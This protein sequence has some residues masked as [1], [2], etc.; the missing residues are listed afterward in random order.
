MTKSRLKE[1]KKYFRD[2]SA[3]NPSRSEGLASGTP[4]PACLRTGIGLPLG[5]QVLQVVAV[6]PGLQQRQVSGQEARRPGGLLRRQAAQEAEAKGQRP[7]REGEPA[8]AGTGPVLLRPGP[9]GERGPA[10]LLPGLQVRLQAQQVGDGEAFGAEPGAVQPALVDAET[11]G[12]QLHPRLLLAE[13][14]PPGHHG[15]EEVMM[16]RR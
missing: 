5:L 6:G 13:L 10:G 8:E 9:R 4:L 11:R 15:A 14:L 7:S 3:Q 1:G 12:Q 2:A 16:Q